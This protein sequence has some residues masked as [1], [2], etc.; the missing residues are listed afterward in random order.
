M[1]QSRYTQ[2]CLVRNAEENNFVM[3]VYCGFRSEKTA[4][5]QRRSDL[6]TV[7]FLRLLWV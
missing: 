3:V 4:E 1:Q 5:C 7:V 6:L 2:Y